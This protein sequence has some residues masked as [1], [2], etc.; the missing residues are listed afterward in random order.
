[1]SDSND[2]HALYRRLVGQ[3][4]VRNIDAEHNSAEQYAAIWSAALLCQ[5][6][7]RAAGIN[8]GLGRRDAVSA[9]INRGQATGRTST[10][11]SFR[12]PWL[13]SVSTVRSTST[14]LM[15]ETQGSKLTANAVG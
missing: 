11:S 7:D 2:S 4:Y 14:S 15:V 8:G 1:M 12:P 10:T 6:Y 13:L 5:F 9:T 3:C